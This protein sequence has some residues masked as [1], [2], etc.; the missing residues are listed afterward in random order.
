MDLLKTMKI[1]SSTII[2]FSLLSEEVA[3]GAGNEKETSSRNNCSF[4]FC[5]EASEVVLKISALL[6]YFLPETLQN[7]N[8]SNLYI[9]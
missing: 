6:I 5:T 4:N 2:S 1:Y 3:I 9:L 7:K 8:F